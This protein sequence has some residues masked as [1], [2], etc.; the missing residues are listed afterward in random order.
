MIGK[1]IRPG[2]NIVDSSSHF[3]MIGAQLCYW[4]KLAQ[5]YTSQNITIQHQHIKTCHITL[6]CNF[7]AHWISLHHSRTLPYRSRK[8]LHITE[9]FCME[10]WHD[11]RSMNINCTDWQI[12]EINLNRS[13]HH[14]MYITEHALICHCITEHHWTSPAY[15]SMHIHITST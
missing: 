3:P 4:P 5:H 13:A 7:N 10:P 11:G 14:C 6:L 15:N 9:Y 8:S 12:K 1:K 2:T